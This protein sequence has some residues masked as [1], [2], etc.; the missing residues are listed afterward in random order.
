M[1]WTV[2]LDFNNSL[3]ANQ[4]RIELNQTAGRSVDMSLF[5]PCE[6][7]ES[8]L[9]LS[10]RV[11]DIPMERIFVAGEGSGFLQNLPIAMAM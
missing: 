10:I 1:Q 11:G 5:S 8:R 3:E 4:T 2:L 9:K 7:E 6:A